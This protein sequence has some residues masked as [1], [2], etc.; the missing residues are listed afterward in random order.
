MLIQ[1]QEDIVYNEVMDRFT[2]SDRVPEENEVL[3]CMENIR[4]AH[5][6]DYKVDDSIKV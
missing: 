1:K 4:E 6:K 3:R 5:M 2:G